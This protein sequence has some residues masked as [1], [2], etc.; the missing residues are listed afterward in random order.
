MPVFDAYGERRQAEVMEDTWGHLKPKKEITYTGWI[1]VALSCYGDLIIID[2]FFDGL[3]ASPWQ[4]DEFWAN[5]YKWQDD[6]KPRVGVWQFEGTYERPHLKGV[7]KK[8]KA[9]TKSM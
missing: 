9:F 8:C 3:E 5:I 2:W 6:E 1:Q 7:W 4:F